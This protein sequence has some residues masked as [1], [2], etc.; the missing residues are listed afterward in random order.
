[1][2]IPDYEVSMESMKI[3][4]QDFGFLK[5]L[6]TS[7]SYNSLLRKSTGEQSDLFWVKFWILTGWGKTSSLNLFSLVYLKSPTL[8]WGIKSPNVTQFP[9]ERKDSWRKS[10]PFNW[11]IFD[12][13]SSPYRLIVAPCSEHH[14][15]NVWVLL[16]TL[17]QPCR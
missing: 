8:A 5:S 17:A 13:T 14:V 12:E 10:V 16:A 6:G 2:I 7:V 4:I 3:N 11:S 9:V 15:K 1:M